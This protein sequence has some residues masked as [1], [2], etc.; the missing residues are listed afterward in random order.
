MKFLRYIPL[1][2]F[3]LMNTGYDLNFVFANTNWDVFYFASM[4]AV[5]MAICIRES[6]GNLGEKLYFGGL[7]VTFG[8]R[9]LSEL[10]QIGE[11][12][13]IYIN[14][15]NSRESAIIYSFWIIILLIVIVIKIWKS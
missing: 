6:Y 2:Y 9:L 1:G 10:R 8:I 15:I 3:A 4:Y 12:Y 14:T 13:D 5:F 11:D 7:F